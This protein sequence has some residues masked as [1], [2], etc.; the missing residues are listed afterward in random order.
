M[1]SSSLPAEGKAAGARE[2]VAEEPGGLSTDH[3][4]ENPPHP[5]S[6][7]SVCPSVRLSVLLAPGLPLSI[8][9]QNPP[10]LSL[11]LSLRVAFSFCDKRG[12]KFCN[13][14]KFF[15]FSSSGPTSAAN[16]NSVVLQIYQGSVQ[17]L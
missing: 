4:G 14:C 1:S 10:S 7:T 5:L 2:Q 15:Q 6:A 12:L 3:F 9:P 17:L 16:A 8:P 11:F 13:F